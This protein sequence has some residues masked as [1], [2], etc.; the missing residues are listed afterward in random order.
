MNSRL[1]IG[2]FIILIL[3]E[4]P[5]LLLHEWHHFHPPPVRSY[6]IGPCGPVGVVLDGFQI[7][8]SQPSEDILDSVD[9]SE[10][11]QTI[12]Q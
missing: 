8:R 12:G 3:I 4:T 6:A 9:C 1:V 7:F 2:F 10:K 5:I 11:H